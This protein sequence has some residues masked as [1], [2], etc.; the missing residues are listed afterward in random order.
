MDTLYDILEVSRTSF[1]YTD[2]G[3]SKLKANLRRRPRP[4]IMSTKIDDRHQAVHTFPSQHMNGCEL[5]SDRTNC[6]SPCAISVSNTL[7]LEMR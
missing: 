5:S 7:L 3:E 4:E 1:C 6:L 2:C